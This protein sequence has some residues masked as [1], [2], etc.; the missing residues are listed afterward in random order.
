M[1]RGLFLL[2]LITIIG[3]QLRIKLVF[4]FKM[5]DPTKVP[6]TSLRRQK[7]EA[8][9]NDDGCLQHELARRGKAAGVL[10]SSKKNVKRYQA[11][12]DWKRRRS[13]TIQEFQ[14]DTAKLLGMTTPANGC[15]GDWVALK[16]RR[17]FDDIRQEWL[18]KIII[19]IGTIKYFLTT[20]TTDTTTTNTTP[21]NL[22]S[23]S[24]KSKAAICQFRILQKTASR[25]FDPNLQQIS[26]PN[27][28]MNTT[29]NIQMSD[30]MELIRETEDSIVDN[31]S[32]KG[33]GCIGTDAPPSSLVSSSTTVNTND[34]GTSLKKVYQN[35]IAT[36]TIDS[37]CT[38][39]NSNPLSP[40]QEH[41]KTTTRSIGNKLSF[42]TVSPSSVSEF[43]SINNNN[44]DRPNGDDN[45]NDMFP[46]AVVSNPIRSPST[47]V[48]SPM[49]PQPS[50]SNEIRRLGNYNGRGLLNHS[51][52]NSLFGKPELAHERGTGVPKKRR[53]RKPVAFTAPVPE[54]ESPSN[55]TGCIDYD[56]KD[57]TTTPD[58]VKLFRITIPQTFGNNVLKEHDSYDNCLAWAMDMY[59]LLDNKQATSFTVPKLNKENRQRGL[60]DIVTDEGSGSSHVVLLDPD[61]IGKLK[62][63]RRKVYDIVNCDDNSIQGSEVSTIEPKFLHCKD[64]NTLRGILQSIASKHPDR[65]VAGIIYRLYITKPDAS[66]NDNNEED[67]TKI[68]GHFSNFYA[69]DLE[70][71]YLDATA[72]EAVYSSD[73]NSYQYEP[74]MYYYCWLP[75]EE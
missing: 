8:A 73:Y 42:R 47:S 10:L 29:V 41:S 55:T 34:G 67:T 65:S 54:S 17:K 23:K 18:K 52:G 57:F 58:L 31:T 38:S 44:E 3:S 37:V 40:R 30:V 45:D 12:V 50:I 16:G 4:F 62:Y 72:G 7:E 35:S 19:C 26:F 32:L 33:L 13:T 15:G 27:Y 24:K 63:Q 69:T 61:Q 28:R 5:D 22:K 56:P 48:P 75:E 68:D 1:L 64:E 36:D 51:G 39:S 2:G 71:W 9:M 21:T 25:Q 49:R 60:C 74:G 53:R 6:S 59:Q 11:E 20:T 66:P 43:T 14:D 46:D 70:V